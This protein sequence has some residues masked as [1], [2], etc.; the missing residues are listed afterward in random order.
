MKRLNK[1][2]FYIGGALLLASCSDINDIESEGYRI[3]G[4]Q[5]D[6]ATEVIPSRVEASIAGMY[7]SMGTVGAAFPSDKRDDDGG[8]PTV[9]LSQDLN[10]ADM[11]CA[12]NGYNWFTVSSDYSDR[13][14]TYANPYARYSIF[15]NQ[16]KAANDIILSIDPE[17]ADETQKYYLGQAKAVRAFDYLCLAPYYQFRYSASKDLPCV[18]LVTETTTDFINNPRATVEKVYEQIISDLNSAIDLLEGY[19]RGSDKTRIDQQV[20]YGLRARA[21]LYMEKW[22]E[23]YNDADKAMEGYAP[24]KEN[25]V[26]KPAFY[27]ISDHNWMWGINISVSMVSKNPYA[28]SPSQLGSFSAYSYTAGV[29]MY[30]NISKLLYDKISTTDVRKQWWVNDKLESKALEGQSWGSASGNDIATLEIE[31]VKMKFTKYANVKF[32]MKSG[33]G[34]SNN[35]ND[36]CIMRA[37][38]MILIK[39][40]ALAQ[41]GNEG[42]AAKELKVL[43]DERDPE[44]WN[45]T[46][47]TADEVWLQRRIELWGEGFSMA[48]I[49]RLGKPV[50]RIKGG[51]IGNW[52]DDFAFNVAPNDPWLLMRI[53]QKE[54]NNNAGIVNNTGGNIPAAGQNADLKD[55][56]TD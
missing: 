40:E 22:E 47:V 5:V 53:P 48:D 30:K 44:G 34:S 45:K 20:A 4:D 52:P 28:T 16:I 51:N 39:A 25:E 18:P 24:Y 15:Y 6:E 2:A 10:G 32:G 12:N 56:A 31:G 33:L 3:T 37:E 55:G 8:Y 49:M 35:D 43:M 26:S 29:A 11:V 27:S 41:Q 14:A 17:T 36:W 1:F 54:S 19:D 46:S 9:C 38:E 7:S 50:V 23:A 42:G 21:H 13:S